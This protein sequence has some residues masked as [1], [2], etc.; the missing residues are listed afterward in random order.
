MA[1]KLRMTRGG[2]RNRPFYRVN[3]VDQRT[4]RDGRVIEQLGFFDPLWDNGAGKF[5]VKLDRAAYWISVGAQ[6]SETVGRLLEKHGVKA[7][8]GTPLD[9]QEVATS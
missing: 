2:N 1:V 7:T 9:Q 5:E 3:A 8:P 4:Q 6:P